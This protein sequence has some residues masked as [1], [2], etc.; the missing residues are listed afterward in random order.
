MAGGF[1]SCLPARLDTQ[2]RSPKR[3]SCQKSFVKLGQYTTLFVRWRWQHYITR[4]GFLVFL[5]GWQISKISA[6]Q[7]WYTT[8]NGLDVTDAEIINA[9][10]QSEQLA[11]ERMGWHLDATLSPTNCY[12]TPPHDFHMIGAPSTSRGIQALYANTSNPRSIMALDRSP[13]CRPKT[14]TVGRCYADDTSGPAWNHL[15]QIASQP[16]DEPIF[17][18]YAVKGRFPN[19]YI[20]I[21]TLEGWEKAKYPIRDGGKGH[22]LI[23]GNTFT[24][25][26]FLYE[27]FVDGEMVASYELV[28]TQ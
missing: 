20:W 8:P 25:G 19:T 10:N 13:A 18:N 4:K 11:S 14:R 2:K 5:I 6:Q 26:I 1:S 21:V 17:I 27:L 22:L 7:S 3:N 16:I 9:I 23:P 24:S 15:A 12:A 28:L